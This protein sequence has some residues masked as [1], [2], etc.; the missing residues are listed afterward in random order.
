VL[1]LA[2]EGRL[3]LAVTL[4]RFLPQYPQWGRVTVRQL[5]N[6]TSGI[7]SYTSSAAFRA[8]MRDALAPDSVLAFVARDTFDFA[9][10]TGSA[11]TTAATSCSAWCWSA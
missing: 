9:P 11:T 6:H 5:L 8:R 10:G 1:R 4:G 2:E 3:S 7:P